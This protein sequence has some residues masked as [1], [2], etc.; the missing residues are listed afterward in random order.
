LEEIEEAFFW[1][2]EKLDI[3]ELTVEN[4]YRLGTTYAGFTWVEACLDS[5]EN[6]LTID[7]NHLKTLRN[8]AAVHSER[9]DFR[10]ASEILSRAVTVLEELPSLDESETQALK[11]DRQNI[12]LWKRKINQHE[13]AMK[14]YESILQD[15]E[16]DYDVLCEM[17][18]LLAEQKQQRQ[19][20][21][22]IENLRSRTDSKTGHD[23]LTQML[24]NLIGDS[25]KLDSMNYNVREMNQ[26]E[27]V[28]ACYERAL[29]I[30]QDMDDGDITETAQRQATVNCL[31][32]HLALFLLHEED[33]SDKASAISLLEDVVMM[34]I[35][36]SGSLPILQT[37]RVA[38]RTLIIC[39]LSE[40]SNTNSDTE[41]A[42]GYI[43]KLKTMAEK[44]TD[45][46]D[47]E[48]I[49]LMLGYYYASTGQKDLSREQI[50]T[51]IQIGI[52]FLSDDDDENDHWGYEKL[53]DGL[54]RFLDDKNALAA[55]SLIGP[56]SYTPATPNP[57][58]S[59]TPSRSTTQDNQTARPL[60]G[61]HDAEADLADPEPQISRT[62][63]NAN[64]PNIRALTRASTLNALSKP[65]GP[66]NIW[67]DCGCGYMWTYADDVY[68]CKQCVH[69]GSVIFTSNCYEKLRNGQLTKHI[70]DKSHEFLHVPPWDFKLAASM[71]P[72]TV[73]VG[74][75]VM[76]IEDWLNG[77]KEEWGLQD[78]SSKEDATKNSKE[79][80]TGSATEA[81]VQ[82]DKDSANSMA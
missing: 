55:W 22:Y 49:R 67:C 16:E 40:A 2:S 44:Y 20:A 32:S 33:R 25:D 19:V 70:C 48:N 24:L 72:K 65:K 15:D 17:I 59:L 38:A 51:T 77:I 82:E 10:L 12:A 79:E 45:A 21:E 42:K 18:S 13:D 80:E 41:Q 4:Y 7:G 46:F 62:D 61:N 36:Y 39:Y 78:T 52:A 31:K 71:K 27:K 54:M 8:L 63:S 60:D 37:K 11:E 35:T 50:F 58:D 47:E 53:A 30:A 28:K 73:L 5:Y 34:T 9:M 74:E 64:V 3:K 56:N 69:N 29:A 1:A 66:L 75:T 76:T 81:G 43:D 23:C 68:V 6:A 26:S 14:I 57:W